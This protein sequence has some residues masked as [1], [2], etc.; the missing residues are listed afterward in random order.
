MNQPTISLEPMTDQ[1][2]SE[3]DA[4][5]EGALP[6]D[7]EESGARMVDVGGTEHPSVA[8]LMAAFG[9][10][11]KAHTVSA[12]DQAVVW[13]E[14]SKNFEILRWL[15]DDAG[16]LY[17]MLSDVTGLDYGAGRAVEVVYQM[18]S[19]SHKRSLR[20]R[21]KLPLDGLEI[22]SVVQLW[23]AA[24]WLER[25]VYDLFGVTFKG[26]PDLRRILMPDDYEEGHPLRKDFPLRGRFSRAEQTRRALLQDVERFYQ[27][28]D[29]QVGGRPQEVLV[30]EST[31]G[32]EQEEAS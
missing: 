28:T 2:P 19:T 18:F 32:L 9:S 20:V 1:P 6:S 8:A 15:K 4:V 14:A 16:Q 10:A 26:H 5:D 31:T 13:V 12:G 7:A 3:L 23:K 21:C 24:D 30:P 27:A 25:E 17:N 29:L 22:D 11:V